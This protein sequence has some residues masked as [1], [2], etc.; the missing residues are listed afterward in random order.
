MVATAPS[1]P[2][3]WTAGGHYVIVGSQRTGI[4]NLFWQA[5]DDTGEAQRLTESPNRQ[6]P[7]AVS[8]DD[9]G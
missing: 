9:T 6:D 8:P 5:P 3:S 4:R 7:T 2:T 1:R